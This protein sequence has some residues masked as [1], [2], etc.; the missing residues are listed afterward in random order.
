MRYE[1]KN[2]TTTY[3]NMAKSTAQSSASGLNVCKNVVCPSSY[4]WLCDVSP[5]EF[6]ECNGFSH[7]AKYCHYYWWSGHTKWPSTQHHDSFASTISDNSM[8][9]IVY[10]IWGLVYFTFLISKQKLEILIPEAFT[11]KLAKLEVSMTKII[12]TW[13]FLCSLHLV[14]RIHY[15]D[16]IHIPGYNIFRK[17]KKRKEKLMW[18][19]MILLWWLGQMPCW[20]RECPGPVAHL[21]CVS[22]QS[23][24]E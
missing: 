15:D 7:K 18:V 1:P 14:L 2:V 10:K 6:H 24:V 19:V 17:E 11:L 3:A 22:R 16:E 12:L 13:H 21:D 5:I 20:S 9:H 8:S 23:R 4:K